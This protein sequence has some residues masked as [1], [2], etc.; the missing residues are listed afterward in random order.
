MSFGILTLGCRARLHPID[1]HVDGPCPSDFPAGT[2]D[3]APGAR[4]TSRCG[5]H[6]V[7]A[8]GPGGDRLGQN[9]GATSSHEFHGVR[10]TCF[11]LEPR[12]AD[13]LPK[14]ELHPRAILYIYMSHGQNTRRPLYQG[15]VRFCIT[16]ATTMQNDKVSPKNDNP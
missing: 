3:F 13:Q 12:K 14:K 10:L 15:G 4:P 1:C 2:R 16:H 9:L 5:A 7:S 6:Q 8:A 11:P